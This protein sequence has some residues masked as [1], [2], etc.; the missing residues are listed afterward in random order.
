ME[1]IT[2]VSTVYDNVQD[3]DFRPELMPRVCETIGFIS[4]VGGCGTSSAALALCRIYSSLF[5]YRTLYLSLDYLASKALIRPGAFHL[6]THLQCREAVYSLLFENQS[7]A[8]KL[9][10]DDF[11][12]FCFP[13]DKYRNSLHFLAE[14][15]FYKL[16]GILESSFDR[17]VL[18]IPLNCHLSACASQLCDTLVVCRGWQQERM[19][20]GDELYSF[21]KNSRD[22]VISFAPGFEEGDPGDIYGRFGAEVRSLAETIEGR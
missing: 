10:R 14:E 18:D 16:V 13:G 20:L 19:A 2:G 8:G 3:A 17:I 12:V 7:L 4:A 6:A 21:L 5:E 15:Q 22:G 1:N 9:I 11:G